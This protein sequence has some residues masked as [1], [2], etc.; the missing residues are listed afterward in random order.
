M[1]MNLTLLLA[2]SLLLISPLLRAAEY[3]ATLQWAKRVELGPLVSGVVTEVTVLPGQHVSRGQVLLKLDPRKYEAILRRASAKAI[4]LGDKRAEARRELDR[5]QE[6]FDRT[7]LSQ[8]DLDLAKLAYSEAHAHYQGAKSAETIAALNLEY[9][10][11]LAPFDAIVVERNVEVGKTIITQHQ[12]VSLITIA[13]SGSMKAQF[14]TDE[15]MLSGLKRGLD[16]KVILGDDKY[17]GFIIDIGLEP[18]A[19]GENRYRVE[20]EFTTG[21]KMQLHAGQRAKVIVP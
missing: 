14:D 8:H 13:G 12:S 19:S 15:R 4:M 3:D 16:V 1:K 20:V 6:L 7:L 11:L 18:I 9:T 2:A 17:D 21:D 5:T 10:Q